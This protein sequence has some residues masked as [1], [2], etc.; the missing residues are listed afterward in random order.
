VIVRIAEEGQFLVDDSA[1]EELSERNAKLD[2]AIM[3]HDEVGFR[4]ALTELLA[5]VRSVGTFRPVVPGVLEPSDVRL[6]GEKA[7]LY[8]TREGPA[9]TA[10][11]L[12]RKLAAANPDRYRPY[13]AA[14]LNNLGARLLSASWPRPDEAIVWGREAVSLYRELAAANPDRYRP[15]LAA[16]LNSLGAQ[17][18]ALGSPDAAPVTEEA[19]S[20]YRELVAA[21]PDRYRP[22]LAASLNSLGVR[23]SALGRP[24]DA[25]PVIEE[26]V[27]IYRESS[28]ANPNRLNPDLAASLNNLDAQL[29]ALGRPG[30][31][32]PVIEEAVSLYRELAAANRDRYRPDLAA[33]LN[34]LGVR[35]SALGR[36]GDAL[37]VIEEA[38]SLYRELPPNRN[39]P[40]SLHNLG[41][42]FSAL[43][44]PDDAVPVME[45][46]VD[47]DQRL[48]IRAPGDSA[49]PAGEGSAQKPRSRQ[50]VAYDDLVRSAFAKL[51]QP[52]R[53]LFN[54]P[55]RMRLG[56]TERVEV[57]LTRTLTLDAQ[58]LQE[59]RGHGKPQLEQ[60][61]TSPVMAV[62]L[63]SDGFQI[64]PYSDE[65]QGVTQD[66]ITTWEFDIRALKR[67]QQRLVISVSLR[68]PVGGQPFER[69]SIPVREAT[70]EVQVGTPALIGHFVAANWQWFVGTVIAIAAVLA[71]VLH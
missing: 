30:D 18:S 39:L 42:L 11:A 56:D 12:Y 59:L 19:V 55:E 66:G 10:V 69:K 70:I 14:S 5:W 17:L 21:K 4:L 24:G 16:S 32:L 51:V 40:A 9:F 54:P 37:P 41:A 8:G 46:A 27:F 38:V 53:L 68:I 57:R 43:G 60:I 29:S 48:S 28:A 22:Y 64:T 23:L 50:S 26:A 13:L 61:P 34:S 33:S 36:P 2:A 6:P 45:E 1:M 52:G 7:S 67:G 44:R 65:E 63:K 62:S 3:L 58:L 49:P 35:L 15:D 31:A 71:A 25:L 47:L 20:L